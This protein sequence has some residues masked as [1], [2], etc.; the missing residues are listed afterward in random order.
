MSIDESL[1]I[2]VREATSEAGQPKELA[3]YLIA[4]LEAT[5]SK[6][7]SKSVELDHRHLDLIYDSAVV[8]RD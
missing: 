8:E 4:W 3:G 1:K 7:I 6:S 2:A 5:Q